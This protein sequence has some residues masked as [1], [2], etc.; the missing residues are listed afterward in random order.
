MYGLACYVHNGVAM[1]MQKLKMAST[2]LSRQ[3]S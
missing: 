3:M 1:K 2:H